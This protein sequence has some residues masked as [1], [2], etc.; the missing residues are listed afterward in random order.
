MVRGHPDAVRPR[1][2]IIGQH[3]R[4]DGGANRLPRMSQIARLIYHNE[5]TFEL[6]GLPATDARCGPTTPFADIA[7]ALLCIEHA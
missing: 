7:A 4:F 6:V 5:L 1:L 2:Q 3:C